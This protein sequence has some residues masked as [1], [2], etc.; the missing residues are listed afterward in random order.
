MKKQK[1]LKKCNIHALTLGDADVKR[2]R[3]GLKAAIIKI[4]LQASMNILKPTEK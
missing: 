3:Q 4:Q 2:I 1:N